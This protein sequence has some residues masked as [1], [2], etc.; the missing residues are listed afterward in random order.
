[1][2]GESVMGGALYWWRRSDQYYWLTALLAAR[3]VQSRTCRLMGLVTFGFGLIPVAM[4]ASPAGPRGRTGMLLALAVSAV[5]V[6]Q[7]F[8]W[9]GGRWP[10]KRRSLIYAT[11]SAICIAVSCLIQSQPLAGLLGCTAFAALAAY[12]AFFHSARFL[13]LNAVLAGA[14]T[15]TIAVRVG[16]HGDPVLAVCAAVS[17]AMAYVLVPYTGHVLMRL[18]DVAE[19]NSDIDPLTGL[20]NRKSFYLRTAELF[21]V[22]GRLDDRYLTIVLIDLDNYLLLADT[23]G[24]EAAERACV[25]VAQTLRE[26]TRGDAVVAR[27]GDS[28]FL[29][30]DTFAT[31]DASPLV[32]RVRGAIATTPPRLTASMGVVCT[33][34][35]ALAELPP[36]ETLDVLIA[37]AHTEM[38]VARRA[39]G[40]QA[41][42]IESAAPRLD[43]W[44]IEPDDEPW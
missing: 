5:S 9:L 33:P 2:L 7:G 42:S 12:V 30:S 32:E 22:R 43:E 8:I 4:L 38:T 17:I 34:L 11:I 31:A 24:L 35:R 3:S 26:T 23:K 28:E 20:L 13:T 27:S 15:V 44:G 29:I 36:E 25:A 1:M 37:L 41:S 6:V 39:G 19:P 10:S 21:S 18:L 16:L 40:N 14:T